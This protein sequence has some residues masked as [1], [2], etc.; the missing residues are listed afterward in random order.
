MKFKSIKTKIT[1]Q[2]GLI[3]LITCGVIFSAVFVF[4]KIQGNMQK[5]ADSAPKFGVSMQLKQNKF[6]FVFAKKIS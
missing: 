6:L 5:V 4:G 1:A 3:L 2:F